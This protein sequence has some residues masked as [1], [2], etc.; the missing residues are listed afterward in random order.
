MSE[1]KFEKDSCYL[2]QYGLKV[3]V[4]A[5]YQVSID[6]V[7]YFYA[8]EFV[9]YQSRYNPVT[10]KY[11]AYFHMLVYEFQKVVSKRILKSMYK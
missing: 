3:P 6:T 5:R 9:L 10:E 11:P 7:K 1:F 4:N 8:S 2:K